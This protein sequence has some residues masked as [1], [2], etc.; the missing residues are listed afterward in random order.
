VF[1]VSVSHGSLVKIFNPMKA[2]YSFAQKKSN[3]L[4]QF[5]TAAVS[6]AATAASPGN[7]YVNIVSITEVYSL[8]VRSELN[9]H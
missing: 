2:S 4:I 5:N 3:L 8:V 7:S 6:A 9:L 1:F